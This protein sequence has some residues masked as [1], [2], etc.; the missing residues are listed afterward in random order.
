M[1]NKT[2]F[3]LYSDLLHTVAKMPTD[4]AGELFKTILEYVN[5]MDPEPEDMVVELVF[6][7]I[8]QQ[9]KR[10]LA[11]WE[12]RAKRSRENGSKGGRPKNPEEPSGLINN[13]DEP[14]KPVNVNVNVNDN[15][16]G[17]EERITAFG[18]SLR[19]YI[20]SH[21]EY[22]PF[23]KDFFE[24]WT[25]HG[26]KEKKF[27]AEKQKSFGIGRR[28]STWKKNS[29]KFDSNDK[30]TTTLDAANKFINR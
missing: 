5:D 6:E 22:I 28:L 7:P 19:T 20:D 15:V 24:Y 29:T 30:P 1:K 11:K 12:Q 13:P 27:R 10:D 4:K 23:A 21:A 3:V 18:K 14:R 26:E 17:I 8:K 2:S 25:E 9:M 16:N